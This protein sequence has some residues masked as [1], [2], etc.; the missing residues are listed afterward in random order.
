MEAENSRDS[1]NASR[2]SLESVNMPGMPSRG[3]FGLSNPKLNVIAPK[4]KWDQLIPNVHSAK[5]ALAKKVARV[6]MSLRESTRTM[7]VVSVLGVLVND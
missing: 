3:S 6:L 1:L 4:E 5:A 7:M 2:Q